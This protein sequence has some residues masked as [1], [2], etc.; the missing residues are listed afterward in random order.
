MQFLT[1]DEAHQYC[2]DKLQQDVG[3]EE[4]KE[5]IEVTK[6][7]ELENLESKAYKKTGDFFSAISTLRQFSII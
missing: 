1:I 2:T 5:V 7:Y 6:L 4:L 3:E